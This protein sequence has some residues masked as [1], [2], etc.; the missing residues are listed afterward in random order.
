MPKNAWVEN[1]KKL[2][3]S[4]NF[5]INIKIETLVKLPYARKVLRYNLNF[6]PSDGSSMP[7]ETDLLIYE[8]I[9]D[10]LKLRI[11]IEAKQSSITTHDAITYSY[12]FAKIAILKEPS[13]QI[14][15]CKSAT[16]PPSFLF[17]DGE[18]DKFQLLR[19]S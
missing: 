12:K 3:L 18:L 1:I 14:K 4:I 16:V 6:E 10:I 5:P 11:L 8:Q 19:I 17:A 15:P 13:C 7:F 2:I 9:S